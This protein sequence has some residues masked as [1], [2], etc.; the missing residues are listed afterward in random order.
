[1]RLLLSGLVFALAGCNRLEPE[2]VP[3]D[4]GPGKYALLGPVGLCVEGV[5]NGKV[6]MR[7]ML[8][9]SGVS[10]EEVFTVHTRFKLFDPAVPVRQFALQRDGSL[11]GGG[12][13]KLRDQ[14]GKEFK[15]VGG[16]GFDAVEGRR[17]DTVILTA[18]KPEATDVLTFESVAGAQGDLT[19][20][21][22]GNYQPQREDGMFAQLKDPGT[23]RFR[24]P[25]AV[26]SAPAPP[27]E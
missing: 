9:A 18:E 23:F 10:K 12:G 11:P 27:V 21:V 17:S 26:W 22:P 24:I 4:A 20:D 25:Q 16:F 3:T 14:A 7:G 5:R 13:L 8:G 1:M 15:A 2:P 6:K 19:L